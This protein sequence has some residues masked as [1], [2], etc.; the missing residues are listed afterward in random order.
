MGRNYITEQCCSVDDLHSYLRSWHP[1]DPVALKQSIINLE[2]SIYYE[3]EHQNRVTIVK[4]LIS[5]RNAFNK[6]VK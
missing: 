6:L 2:Q 1:T 3:K 4:M 5:K